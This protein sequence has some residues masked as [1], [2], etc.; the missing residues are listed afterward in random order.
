MKRAIVLAAFVAVTP[1]ARAQLVVIDPA[2]LA[3]DGQI[4]V[5][6]A[7]QVQNGIKEVGAMIHGNG[8]GSL[9][10][11]LSSGMATNPLGA[12][13]ASATALMSGSGTGGGMSGLYSRFT[14]QAMPYNP[15]GDDP[16]AVMLRQRAQAAA[17][18]MAVAQQ[19]VNGSTNRLSLLPQ[20]ATALTGTADVKDAVDVNTRVNS[21]QMTQGAQQQ[22]LQALAL[23]QQGE[24]NA[25]RSRVEIIWRQGADNY[26]TK[27][28]AAADA[29]AAGQVQLVTN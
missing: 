17:G 24:Q 14:S 16:Q 3:K 9:V 12:D 15:T 1:A 10:P 2:T 22:E 27:A 18:Q 23:Y 11:G 19:F 8:F 13:A 21:E 5:S 28:Q 20:L 4:A 7:Q 29:A 25:Q 6:T 26:A